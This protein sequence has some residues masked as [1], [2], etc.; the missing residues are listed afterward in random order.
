[1]KFQPAFISIRKNLN[2]DSNFTLIEAKATITHKIFETKSSFH[3]K[4]L[5]TGKV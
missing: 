5:A 4:Q 2:D 1:M 3:V